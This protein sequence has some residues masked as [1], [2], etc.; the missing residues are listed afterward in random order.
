MEQNAVYIDE[1]GNRVSPEV[2]GTTHDIVGEQDPVTGEVKP[3]SGGTNPIPIGNIQQSLMQ[4]DRVKNFI[5]QTSPSATL[6]SI[7]Y[8]LQGYVYDQ[9]KEEWIQVADGIPDKVRLDFLQFVTPD[10]SED[11]RMTNLNSDQINA[12][13]EST[14]EWIVDYLDIIADE[15]QLQ[16][17]QMSKIGWILIK[18]VFYTILRA[19][20]GVERSQIFRSLKMGDTLS[21][22]MPMQKQESWWK[23]WK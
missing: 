20:A 9:N 3:M 12:I 13:M 21:P 2:V 11:V 17:E 1:N 10:L 19:Q 22:Q 15:E 8:I 6:Q 7:N 16:E 5:S 23:F 14:I 4:E 18:S